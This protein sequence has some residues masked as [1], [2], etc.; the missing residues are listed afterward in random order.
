MQHCDPDELA[1][2]A[3][4]EQPSPECAAHL[5]DCAEC[6][7]EVAS[8]RRSVDVLAVPALAAP[9]QAMAP[10]PQ[11]WAAI[12]AATGVT[13]SPRPAE[14]E[15]GLSREVPMPGPTEVETDV[16]GSTDS[17][18]AGATVMPFRSRSARRP[19]TRWL[20]LA[21]A[22]LV[23][24]LI[25][26]GA[27]AVTQD[28]PGGAVVAQAGLDPLPEQ[29]ASGN[30]EVRERGGIRE[31]QVDLD[32]PALQDAYYE[33]WLLQADAQRMVPVGIV[34]QGA[35]VL[36]LPDGIDLAAYPLVD[37][38]VEPLDGDPTHSGVSVVRGELS[39]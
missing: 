20:P 15:A 13:V 33:V 19:A 18:P 17:T 1:L 31:L 29:I 26:A 23:G 5:T 24:G 4:G 6:E 35:T 11:V 30:A 21:A 3:L 32:V 12:A 27:V 37:V 10:P 22:V 39:T 7:Q 36:R 34:R 38:S 8:L 25:G 2:A 14:I 16:P 28:G 9:S